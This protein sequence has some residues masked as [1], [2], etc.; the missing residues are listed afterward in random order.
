MKS[1][2]IKSGD[3]ETSQTILLNALQSHDR[4][5]ISF[6]GAEDVVLID[7]ACNLSSEF[8]V[9]CL[10]TGR[11]HPETYRFIEE[12]R[13]YYGLEIDVIS[14]NAQAVADLVKKKGLFSFY[15]EGH[16]ECCSI[17]KI[18]PLRRHLANFDAWI[19]GQRRDQS[20]TRVSVPSIQKDEAFSTDEHLVTKYNPLAEW[21]SDQIW[22]YIKS[23]KVPYNK[24]HDKGYMSI[25]CEPCTR[26]TNPGQHEREG[27]WWWE[28]A[29]D[30]ECGLH[31]VNELSVN[32]L[33]VNK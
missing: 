17:R 31:I 3:S 1:H 13:K 12:T 6:S 25:G 18:E 15:E 10:D 5:A 22:Q 7:M 16:K 19:T 32:K 20:L 4:V 9:F 28:D 2:E 33:S 23:N 30:K 14:P 27:R 21:T 29:D 26:P 8:S 24:L 11:L